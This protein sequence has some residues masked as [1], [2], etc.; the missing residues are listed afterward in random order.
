MDKTHIF[1]SG[2]FIFILKLK[3]RVALK[4]RPSYTH[5][6]F[7]SGSWGNG[8]CHVLLNT[9]EKKRL[10]HSASESMNLS[11][12][13]NS[14]N[15]S[16]FRHLNVETEGG[17]DEGQLKRGRGGVEEGEEKRDWGIILLLILHSLQ[18]P[19]KG[20]ISQCEA[21]ETPLPHL[22]SQQPAHLSLPKHLH[23]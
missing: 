19:F 23:S 12:F 3:T 21:P 2:C 13:H 18:R 14:F 4:L 5:W 8:K 16:C 7:V 6:P 11:K 1:S 20:S 22:P 15:Y 10:A 17:G 9:N